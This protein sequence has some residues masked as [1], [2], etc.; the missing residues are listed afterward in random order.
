MKRFGE[1][2]PATIALGAAAGCGAIA[3]VAVLLPATLF[4]RDKASAGV[5]VPHL[6]ALPPAESRPFEDYD[7]V[8]ERPLFNPGREADP[9][10]PAE[11]AKSQLPALSEYRLVGIVLMK[12]VKL[13][14][15]ERRSSKQV[16]TVHPGEALDGRRVGDIEADGI[17]LSGGAGPEVLAMPRASG[18]SRS[19][20]KDVAAQKD[21]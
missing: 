20:S 10:P 8:F 17:R 15:V 18:I 7:A 2:P 4:A 9:K 3:L 21:Q 5:T 6:T 16:V 12:G 13:G 1:L 19:G 11:A 14:L